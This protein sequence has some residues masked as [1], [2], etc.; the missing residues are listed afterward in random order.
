MQ[1]MGNAKV[2]A[3]NENHVKTNHQQRTHGEA[4]NKARHMGIEQLA[5]AKHAKKEQEIDGIEEGDVQQEMVFGQMPVEEK[6]TCCKAA[7]TP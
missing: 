6:Q 2:S 4:K 3:S 5:A 7:D 1:Q